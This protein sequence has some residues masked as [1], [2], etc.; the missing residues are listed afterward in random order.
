[1]IVSLGDA[2]RPMSLERVLRAIGDAR[3]RFVNP[4]NLSEEGG[5]PD[6]ANV[7][8]NTAIDGTLL[9]DQSCEDWSTNNDQLASRLGSRNKIT[10]E[11]TNREQPIIC[12]GNFSI[13]CFEQE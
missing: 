13:Y 9:S 8:S 11:W 4:I 2:R 6:S 12:S 3:T 5:E 1:E 7:W 10:S